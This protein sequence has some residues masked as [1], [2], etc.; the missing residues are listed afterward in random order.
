[1]FLIELG[2]FGHKFQVNRVNGT[3]DMA[4]LVDLTHFWTV[5]KDAELR[6]EF[7][8]N[9]NFGENESCSRLLEISKDIRFMDFGQI[10]N[11]LCLL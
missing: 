6:E 9:G 8:C 11:E 4:K 5:Y 1:M 7:E 2:I 3:Q 10:Y